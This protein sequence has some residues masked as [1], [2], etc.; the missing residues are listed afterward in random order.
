MVETLQLKARD[1]LFLSERLVTNRLGQYWSVYAPD[2]PGMPVVMNGVAF[3]ILK[4]FEGGGR[5]CD[6]LARP[7]AD[8][9]LEIEDAVSCVNHFV[10]RG[11]VGKNTKVCLY[12]P[13]D[14]VRPSD[15]NSFGVWLHLTNKC[16]LTCPYCFV[17]KNA[18]SM[19]DDVILDVANNI[20]DSSIKNNISKIELRLAG[21][22][23]T[24]VLDKAKFLLDKLYSGIDKQKTK[25]EVV[26][27][28]NGTLVT[29]KLIRF[30]K[31]YGVGI[32]ISLDGF[33]AAHDL[34]RKRKKSES[35][36]WELIKENISIL[37]SNGVYPYIL[38]TISE[39]SCAT[40]SQLTEW[41]LANDLKMKLRI[42]KE[43]LNLLNTNL[44]EIGGYYKRYTDSLCAS[45]EDMFQLVEKERYSFRSFSDLTIDNY[46]FN[47]PKY[48]VRCGIG[49]NYIVIKENGSIVPCHMGINEKG[50][51]QADDILLSAQKT[52]CI[53]PINRGANQQET[54][55]CLVC[56]WFP[57]CV[58]GC[59]MN[60][61][62]VTGSLYSKSPLHCF[63]EYVIPRY[64]EAYSRKLLQEAGKSPNQDFYILDQYAE[65]GTR[66][67]DVKLQ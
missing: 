10:K 32:S 44:H 58:G 13:V 62:A 14:F 3:S 31:Q 51:K 64:L 61:L 41:V 5:V 30:L 46:C 43:P 45:F 4:S 20:L 48:S 60:N 37:K 56:R 19:S 65:T 39:Q 28:S 42:V 36:T 18:A 33:G 38:A 25:L 9:K 21:G 47:K 54:H 23:P 26:L 59:P 17:D 67:H 66:A 22:E 55:D 52:I 34:C 8:S 11:F 2:V 40:L 16:N 6:A 35:G 29:N 1:S 12:E 27:L 15:I 53:S 63:Y 57:V 49:E 24:L 7:I 50:L